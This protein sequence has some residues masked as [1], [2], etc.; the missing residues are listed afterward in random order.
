MDRNRVY[1][2]LLDFDRDERRNIHR[3][4]IL[5]VFPSPDARDVFAPSH[6]P[7]PQPQRPGLDCFAC[8][9]DEST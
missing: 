8:G 9:P 1:L 6:S 3:G 7:G 5:L 4:G 2:D